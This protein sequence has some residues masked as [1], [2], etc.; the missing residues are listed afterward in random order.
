M[1][2]CDIKERKPEVKLQNGSTSNAKENNGK[3][4]AAKVVGKW[5]RN[6]ANFERKNWKAAEGKQMKAEAIQEEMEMCM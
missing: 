1:G 5:L 3:M 4:A 2:E 6:A